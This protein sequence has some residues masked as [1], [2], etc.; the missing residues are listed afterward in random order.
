VR[1]VEL[2]C[3]PEVFAS[4]HIAALRPTSPLP[5]LQ[6]LPA[7]AKQFA[8]KPPTEPVRLRYGSAYYIPPKQWATFRKL[9]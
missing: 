5:P 4:L 1:L 3:I 9:S 6:P 2:E 7:A 8:G